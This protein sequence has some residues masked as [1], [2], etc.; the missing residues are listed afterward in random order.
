MRT[1]SKAIGCVVALALLCAPQ[2][3]A[4]TFGAG[5]RSYVVESTTIPAMSPPGQAPP[6]ICPSG[7]RVLSGGMS[8]T[9]GFEDLWLLGSN[10]AQSS[11]SSGYHKWI[12]NYQTFNNGSPIT[13]RGYAICDEQKPLVVEKS[14][15]AGPSGLTSAKAKCPGDLHVIGGGGS[16][17]LNNGYLLGSQPLD[18]NDSDSKP[19][20]G[21]K[22]TFDNLQPEELDAAAFALCAKTKPTYRQSTSAPIP[23]GQ[24]GSA[25]AS[26][27]VTG[28]KK[29]LVGGGHGTP[30]PTITARVNASNPRIDVADEA[31][32][33]SW[34]SYM[35]VRFGAPVTLTV[36]AICARKA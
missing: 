22:V 36:Y 15:V 13:I 10:P 4:E 1:E 2:A 27:P 24:Q 8:N 16:I 28:K 20:D 11:G 23:V 35:D 7:E 29:Y 34:I 26:C 12:A 25:N 19:D 32:S 3:A 9:A 14:F 5:G 31:P 30:A 33:R 21:W 18:R 17:Q 6:A